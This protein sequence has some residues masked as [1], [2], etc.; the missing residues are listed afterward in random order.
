MTA[1][2]VMVKRYRN[3]RFVQ[4]N[5]RSCGHS[6][7]P[8]ESITGCPKPPNLFS[9]TPSPRPSPHGEGIAIVRL[10]FTGRR[11]GHLRRT[12]SPEA[13]ERFSFSPGEK[14]G[15]RAS[16]KTILYQLARLSRCAVRA[17]VQ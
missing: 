4:T 16:V 5:Y 1:F 3:S 2:A 7:G 14:V 10:P 11:C 6:R 12:T 15:M 17:A 9:R 8:T 13:G